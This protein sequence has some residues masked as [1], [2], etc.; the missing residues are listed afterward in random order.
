[1]NHAY[2]EACRKLQSISPPPPPRFTRKPWPTDSAPGGR[3][4]RPRPRAFFVPIPKPYGTRASGASNGTFETEP[5][6]GRRP[7]GP[8]PSLE[9]IARCRNCAKTRSSA[10]GS[11]SRSSGP[12]GPHDF[13]HQDQSLV[14]SGQCPFCE[15]H[16]DQTPP[17]IVAYR[18]RGGR[19]NGPGWRVRVDPE[20]VPRAQDRGEPQQAGRGDLRH[21]GRRRRPRGHHREPQAP[22]QHGRPP[23][24]EHPRGPLGLPRPPDRPQEGQPARPRPDLQERRPGRRRQPR[25]HPQPAHRHTHRADLGLPRRWPAAWSST[26]TGAGAST[27]T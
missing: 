14:E 3:T 24:G 23:R 10:A 21:D 16:E 27:A 4:A 22:P 6:A 17:E 19:P 8:A 18:E 12:N 20:Q 2:G 5:A 11:S 1:M 25:A 26:T 7:R 15:G 13:K 9:G